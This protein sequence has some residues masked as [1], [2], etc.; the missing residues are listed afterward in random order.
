[1]ERELVLYW[2]RPDTKRPP[3]LI[4]P[5]HAAKMYTEDPRPPIPHQVLTSSAMGLKLVVFGFLPSTHA[6]TNAKQMHAA[7]YAC[8]SSRSDHSRCR[9]HTRLTNRGYFDYGKNPKNPQFDPLARNQE[10]AGSGI[11]RVYL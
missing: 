10:G 9:W 11:S 8:L 1:M 7:F 2:H 6:K 4:I 5:V 3:T